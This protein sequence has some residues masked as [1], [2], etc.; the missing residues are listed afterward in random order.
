MLSPE[1]WK[2]V[3]NIAGILAGAAVVANLFHWLWKQYRQWRNIWTLEQGK[4]AERY[5]REEILRAIQY[6]VKPDCQ[7]VD[8]GGGE[9]FRLVVSTREPL[10][11]ATDRLLANPGQYKH[12]ILLADSGMGKTSFLLNYY[13]WHRRGWRRRKRFRLALVPLNRPEADQWIREIPDQRHTVLFLDALDE[14]RQAISDHRERIKELVELTKDF[15]STVIT[16]RAQF[17][18]KD[19]EIPTETGIIKTGPVKM[20]DAGVYYFHKLYLSPFSDEQVESYLKRRYRW[21]QYQQRRKAQE[22]VA[23]IPDLVARPML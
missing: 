22:I 10:F 9:D 2:I 15:K 23:K 8:P 16:C 21:R 13:A 11:S 6:Y 5:D 4:G 3:V 7:S 12:I 17:F 1:Q 19:E 18:P 14:D 20:G